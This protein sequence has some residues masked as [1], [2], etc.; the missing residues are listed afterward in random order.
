[1]DLY[2][3]AC[4]P[5]LDGVPA[6]RLV[7]FGLVVPYRLDSIG[8]SASLAH[9]PTLSLSLLGW[10]TALAVDGAMDSPTSLVGLFWLAAADRVSRR[11]RP[12]LCRHHSM[13]V[14]A[15]ETAKLAGCAN[16]LDRPGVGKGLLADGVF[17]VAVGAF[18]SRLAA[19]DTANLRPCRCLRSVLLLRFWSPPAWK[20]VWPAPNRSS[21]A[22]LW[23][24]IGISISIVLVCLSYGK[25]RMG[26]AT[27]TMTNDRAEAGL[28]ATDVTSSIT[29]LSDKN[30]AANAGEEN[31]LLRVV[32]I[33][34]SLD[35]EFDADQQ[36]G[37]QRVI[38]AFFDYVSLSRQAVQQPVD[39]LIWPESMFSAN[40]TMVTYE[41]PVTGLP[42]WEQSADALRSR[43]DQIREAVESRM[44][45]TAQQV[46]VPLIVGLGWD[47]VVDGGLQRFNSA[48]LLSNEGR[49]KNRYAKCIR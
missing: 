11:L 34:G 15:M 9:I 10:F 3:S 43:L 40:E 24:P 13:F 8:D 12:A 7:A 32:L 1:M 36:R 45:W 2:V 28:A 26:S 39:V 41:S 48:V 35:T 37:E 42:G 23:L 47:H 25:I 5:A 16:R 20:F 29:T 21:R 18:A 49:V 38:D 30:G 22:S 27:P 33:Q 31:R 4:H 19:A 44:T 17:D 6:R 14:A 46:G